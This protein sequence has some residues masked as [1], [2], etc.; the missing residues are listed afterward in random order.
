LWKASDG[1]LEISF[2]ATI[3]EA[4]RF[5]VSRAGNGLGRIGIGGILL[6]ARTG[7]VCA[8]LEWVPIQCDHSRGPSFFLSR[9]DE[10]KLSSLLERLRSQEQVTG[11]QV[12]GWFAAHPRKSLALTREEAELHLRRFPGKVALTVKPDQFGALQVAVHGLGDS[13]SAS[14]ALME[15]LFTVEPLPIVRR[16]GGQRRRVGPMEPPVPECVPVVPAR[17]PQA[18]Q[19]STSWRTAILVAT[20]LLGAVLVGAVAARTYRTPELISARANATPLEMLSLHA[21]WNSGR[22]VVSWNGLAAPIT[23]ATRVTLLLN[24]GRTT[25]RRVLSRADARAGIQYF[26]RTSPAIVANLVLETPSGAVVTEGTRLT[27][28]GTVAPHPSRVTPEML[29][30]GSERVQKF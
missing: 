25:R 5:E 1:G 10:S 6:G 28:P 19:T 17:T 26:S 27:A 11:R 18:P 15:P 23:F 12:L 7:S 16:D 9:S 20:A 29:P 30:P 4:I 22:A 8:V 24:D 3:L 14:L 2:A 13:G 21:E